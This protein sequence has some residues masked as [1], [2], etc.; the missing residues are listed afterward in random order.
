MFQFSLLQDGIPRIDDV[1]SCSLIIETSV[2][3]KTG[4]R[5]IEGNLHQCACLGNDPKWS[6]HFNGDTGAL[7]VIS[8]SLR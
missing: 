1:A 7:S 8:K 6:C 2:D 3:G 5:F 4:Y